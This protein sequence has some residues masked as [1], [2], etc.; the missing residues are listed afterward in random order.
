M[1]RA[2]RFLEK[3]GVKILGISSVYR[4]IP[5]GFRFQPSFLNCVIRATT[6]LSPFALLELIKRIERKLGRIKLFPNAPRTID[7]DI[8]FYNNVVM[9]S[10]EL[11][12]PH[13]RLKERAFAL[14]PL[15]ELAPRLRHPVTG[16][17]VSAM[18]AATGAAGVQRWL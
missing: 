13:P 17:T 2:E 5:R 3:G 14:A 15:A 16:E 7:I 4:T 6:A 9:D 1:E 18:L 8:I 12:I 10:P 11:T